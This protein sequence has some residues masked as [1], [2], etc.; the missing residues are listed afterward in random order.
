[1]NHSLVTYHV[2]DANRGIS[3]TLQKHVKCIGSKPISEM[4]GEGLTHNKE[5]MKRTSGIRP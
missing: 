4:Y 2:I 5:H 3:H 1:M